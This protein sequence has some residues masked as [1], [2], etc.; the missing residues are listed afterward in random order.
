M[1]SA[2]DAVGLDAGDG[3]VLVHGDA[4]LAEDL[5]QVGAALGREP[6]AESAAGGEG[7][8]EVRAGLGDLGRGLHAGE[9]AADDDHG[10]ARVQPGQPLAQPEC[11]RTAGDLVGVLVG[12]GDALVVP[13][14]A[15]GVDQGVVR[16]FLGRAV[17]VRA[18]HGD[19]PAV[20]I[21]AGDLRE[22]HLD[23]GA[24]EHLAER[25]GL[26]VLAD[27]ELV[28]SDPFDEVGLGVD[29]GDGDVCAVQPLGEAP[30]GDGS[31]C[32]RLRGR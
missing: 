2:V 18:D 20:D 3:G 14:A 28:H 16:Q 13:G 15:E 17:A 27:R 7:D 9:S 8:V 29:E 26:E 31:G 30:G 32:S 24:G 12:A 23:A 4:E 22:L 5:P 19:G 21:D 6:V 1:P 10:P 25:P 11:S